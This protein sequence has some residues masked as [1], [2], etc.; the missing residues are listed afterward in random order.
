MSDDERRAEVEAVARVLDDELPATRYSQEAVREVAEDCIVALD[1]VRDAR[2]DD[3]RRAEIEAIVR[4]EAERLGYR[5]GEFFDDHMA[6]VGAVLDR[7]RDARGGHTRACIAGEIDPECP[8][9]ARSPR[10]GPR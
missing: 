1:R 10:P 8:C 7:V 4:A 9:E 5:P 2:G 3:E 6:I